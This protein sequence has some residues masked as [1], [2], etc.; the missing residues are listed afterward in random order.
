MFDRNRSRMLLCLYLLT[1]CADATAP[2]VPG[3]SPTTASPS[4]SGEP[5]EEQYAEMPAEFRLPPNIESHEVSAGFTSYNVAYA[6]GIMR[7]RANYAKETV[8]L[9]L[10]YDNAE[11]TSGTN[12]TAETHFL[13]ARRSIGAI[14]SSAAGK[15][16][17]HTANADATG[18][19]HNEF[20]LSGNFLKWGEQGASGSNNS[21]QP[22]C[23][24]PDSCGP[25]EEAPTSLMPNFTCGGGGDDGGGGGDGGGDG[26]GGGGGWIAIEVC[27]GTHYF[28]ENWN[29]LYSEIHYCTTTWVYYT[30]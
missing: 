2:G 18:E 6:Q 21:S 7:Y 25:G 9:R 20:F 12:Y 17:G 14:V 29:Y 23:P 26:G 16:C 8:T 5:T 1:A 22:A 11:V 10:V 4:F 30:E 28:D 19:I 13:P 24:P 3:T 27:H 15:T